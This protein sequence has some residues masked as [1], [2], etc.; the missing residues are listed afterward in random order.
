MSWQK[1]RAILGC[2]PDRDV[3]GRSTHKLWE[4]SAVEVFRKVAVLLHRSLLDLQLTFVWGGQQERLKER[5]NLTCRSCP[6]LVNPSVTYACVP[7]SMPMSQ[8]AWDCRVGLMLWATP[9]S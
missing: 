4:N 1:V 5:E 3:Q 9:A 6:T 8:P 2:G 7:K